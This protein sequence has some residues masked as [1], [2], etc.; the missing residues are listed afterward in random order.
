MFF[1]P[2]AIL[3][4]VQ[5]GAFEVTTRILLR[6]RSFSLADRAKN[7]HLTNANMDLPHIV[8]FRRRIANSDALGPGVIAAVIGNSLEPPI[9][10]V[11]KIA[12]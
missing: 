12:D 2:I 1:D 5:L 9:V 6:F 4:L 8:I 7:S 10:S 11:D 3:W